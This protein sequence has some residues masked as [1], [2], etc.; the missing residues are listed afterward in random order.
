M[1]GALSRITNPAFVATGQ[2]GTAKVFGTFNIAVWGTFVGTV[3]LERTLDGTNWIAVATDGI[4]TAAS[5]TSA[6]SITGLEVES[7][8][9]YRFNCTAYTSG[10]IN[11][12]LSQIVTDYHP[13]RAYS[14]LS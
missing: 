14:R 3:A 2:S 9:S 8:V 11:C 10:T 7:E 4:G 1:A 13:S 5:F 6:V 12:R